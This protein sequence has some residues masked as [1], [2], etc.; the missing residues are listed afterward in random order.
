MSAANRTAHERP[1][2]PGPA[3]VVAASAP[4]FAA[5][6]LVFQR[7]WDAP[8]RS[9]EADLVWLRRQA[10]KE[11][12]DGMTPRLDEVAEG[13]AH[14]ADPRARQALMASL[15][16]AREELDH[17]GR[18]ADAF[19]ELSGRRLDPRSLSAEGDWHANRELAEVRARHVQTSGLV[20]VVASAFTEGGCCTLYAEGMGRAGCGPADDVIA[21]ACGPVYDDEVAHMRSAPLPRIGRVDRVGVATARPVGRRAVPRAGSHARRAVRATVDRR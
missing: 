16:E 5:E 14:A 2:V 13:I 6:A 4:W 12:C 10:Y 9:V 15:H 17:F 11:L 8:S 20:G 7:Y 18:F 19:A 3:D 1:D 21:A